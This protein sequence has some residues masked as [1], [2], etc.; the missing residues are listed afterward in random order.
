[1]GFVVLFF[2]G[3]YF[4]YTLSDFFNEINFLVFMGSAKV[5]NTIEEKIV[6]YFTVQK[7]KVMLNPGNTIILCYCV[8]FYSQDSVVLGLC[9]FIFT[10]CYTI[11]SSPLVRS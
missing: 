3:T 9:K 11:T 8:H 4:T 1:M 7:H 2:W 6:I 5:K 10:S